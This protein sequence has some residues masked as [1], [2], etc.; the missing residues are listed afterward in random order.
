[1]CQYEIFNSS[2]IKNAIKVVLLYIKIVVVNVFLTPMIEDLRVLWEKEI[3][4]NDAYTG[5]N[6]KM[7]TMLF[8]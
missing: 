1:M 2:L 6:F 7:C 8:F 5:D 4:V 3:D